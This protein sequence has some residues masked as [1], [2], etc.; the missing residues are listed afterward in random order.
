MDIKDVWGQPLMELNPINFAR[1][2]LRKAQE[3]C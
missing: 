3:K 1:A 2:I